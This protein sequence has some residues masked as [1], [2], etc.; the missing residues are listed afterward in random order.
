MVN[1]ARGFGGQ[2]IE[3][4]LVVNVGAFQPNVVEDGSKSWI[5]RSIDHFIRY[6][7]PIYEFVAKAHPIIF[8][9]G[10]REHVQTALEILLVLQRRANLPSSRPISLLAWLKQ[11]KMLA[12]CFTVFSHRDVLGHFD[13]SIAVGMAGKNDRQCKVSVFA[14]HDQAHAACLSHAGRSLRLPGNSRTEAGS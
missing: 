5:G 9:R 11:K 14:G 12:F 8:E 1:L 7:G 4:V 3:S 10:A 2:E 6:F 13:G